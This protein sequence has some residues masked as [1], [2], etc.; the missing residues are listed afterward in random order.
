V[1]ADIECAVSAVPKG[2]L[3][4][5][6]GRGGE[7]LDEKGLTQGRVSRAAAKS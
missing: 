6:M 1:R 7:R 3:K 4:R 2:K 5:A